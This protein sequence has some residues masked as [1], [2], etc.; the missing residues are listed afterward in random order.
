[1]LYQAM[2]RCWRFGQTHPVNVYIVISEQEGAVKENIERKER[3]A[4]TMQAEMVKFTKT[5]LEKEIRGTCRETIEYNPQIQ[6]IIP[7][8]CREEKELQWRKI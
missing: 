4:A 3:Q 2:R 7:E 8:W 1:M 6:M 5:I